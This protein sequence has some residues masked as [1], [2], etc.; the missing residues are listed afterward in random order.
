MRCYT[1]V[2]WMHKPDWYRFLGLLIAVI[3]LAL[4]ASSIITSPYAPTK[5]GVLLAAAIISI[6]TL[7]YRLVGQRYFSAI[8]K[9]YPWVWVT[10]PLEALAV[11][12]LLI[13][14][15]LVTIGVLSPSG[16]SCTAPRPSPA[17]ASTSSLAAAQRQ[18]ALPEQTIVLSSLTSSS[19]VAIP[20]PV[21]VIGDETDDEGDTTT[22]SV[23]ATVI[24]TPTS[25]AT[26][27]SAVPPPS[28][29][30]DDDDDDANE[31]L[32]NSAPTTPTLLAAS[33]L[34]ASPSPAPDDDDDDDGNQDPVVTAPTTTTPTSAPLP[35]VTPAPTAVPTEGPDDDAD[36]ISDRRK[37]VKRV[38]SHPRALHSFYR[39][40][41]QQTESEDAQSSSSSCSI[42]ATVIALSVTLFLS[43]A[44][45][46]CTAIREARRI[47]AERR[48]SLA[49]TIA[50]ADGSAA[51]KAPLDDV[52]KTEHGYEESLASSGASKG[53]SFLQKT[54]RFGYILVKGR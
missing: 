9:S 32:T 34:A 24:T 39:R 53:S 19:M 37:L 42:D 45:S 17:V 3:V 49:S 22:P 20:S 15:I 18:T 14:F 28:T 47:T 48:L 11:L 35:S 23:P 30:G 13:G 6:I 8:T 50:A 25:L 38:L 26:I 31:S 46:L 33:T 4:D 51:E 5:H 1:S 54:A 12:L 41:S 10:P 16:G 36:D 2:V 40:Q 29:P 21:V 7:V 52:E 27:V 44:F 43:M